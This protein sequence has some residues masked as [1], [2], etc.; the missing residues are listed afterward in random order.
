M[1]NELSARAGL[2]ARA[3]AYFPDYEIHV[4]SGGK[5]RF[6]RISSRLQIRIV[7]AA[8]TVALAWLLFTLGMIALQ[9]WSASERIAL[10]RRE[11]AVTEST[12]RVAAYRQTIDAK[13]ESVERRQAVIDRVV[14]QHFGAVDYDAPASETRD[15]TSEEISALIPEAEAIARIEQ[16]Q[17]AFARALEPVVEARTRR[18]EAAIREFGLDPRQLGRQA[19]GGPFAP[20]SRL[21]AADSIDAEIEAL[22]IALNRLAA[23]ELSLRAIPS[24]RPTARLAISSAFGFRSDPFNGARAMHTGLD[25]RGSHGQGILATAAGRVVKAS[26]EGGYGMMVEIDHGAGMTTRY[27]HLSGMHVRLGERVTRGQRIGRMGSTGRSTATHLHYEVRIDG[28]AIN[29][30]PFLEAN[31]DVL[32]IQSLA[33]RRNG[34]AAVDG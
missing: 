34:A 19:Q 13:V 3:R 10:D 20:A 26:F 21:G 28:Q 5:L 12:E 2:A 30:R 1:T 31:P 25:F 17:L 11:A 16:R 8:G 18:A 14:E 22:E 6:I 32:E 33:E 4:R 9:F 7:S 24:A 23:I 15:V 27:A 29:P